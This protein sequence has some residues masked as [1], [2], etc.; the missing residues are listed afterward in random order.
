MNFI[1]VLFFLIIDSVCPKAQI[2]ASFSPVIPD[3]MTVE[4]SLTDRARVNLAYS[5]PMY[6]NVGAL[7]FCARNEYFFSDSIAQAGSVVYIGGR[8]CLS[9]AHCRQEEISLNSSYKVGFEVS[10]KKIERY[11]VIHFW[12]HPKYEENKLY[13]IAVLILD[14]NVQGLDGIQ[15]NYTNFAEGLYEDG[16]HLLT[17]IGYGSEI[18][19]NYWFEMPLDG[20]RRGE[21]SY[22]RN[23]RCNL[24]QPVIYST[25]Y[26]YSNKVTE[27]Q[28]RNNSATRRPLIHYQAKGSTGMS[29]GMTVHPVDGFI[30]IT[31]STQIGLYKSTTLFVYLV[32]VQFVRNSMDLFELFFPSVPLMYP[33]MRITNY[34]L[35]EKSVPLSVCKDFI[36]EKRKE[37]EGLDV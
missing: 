24:C 13:D 35:V 1:L 18:S 34:G 31:S 23:V 6:D 12:V 5:N 8:M 10:G 20:K 36:E 30:G 14:K 22:L 33:N 7:Y 9:A 4:E 17:Y 26:G 29:G 37:F 25:P 2:Y 19:S 27:E 21:Q 3:G 16:S 32:L 28:Y 11:D 15:P